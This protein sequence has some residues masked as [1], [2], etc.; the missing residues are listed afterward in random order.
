[1]FMFLS[2]GALLYLL[3]HLY[4]NLTTH[5]LVKHLKGALYE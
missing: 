2:T 5:Q 1:M 4:T 3:S